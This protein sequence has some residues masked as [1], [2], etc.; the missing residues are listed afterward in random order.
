MNDLIIRSAK[1]LL[2]FSLLF[3]L[4]SVRTNEASEVFEARLDEIAKVFETYFPVVE[5]AVVSVSGSDIRINLGKKNGLMPGMVVAISREG[6]ELYHPVTKEALGKYEEEIGRLELKEAGDDYATGLLVGEKKGEIKTGDKARVTG[7]KIKVAL[8]PAN[9]ETNVF[10]IDQFADILEETGRFTVISGGEI[11]K[12][13]KEHPDD[14]AAKIAKRAGDAFKLTNLF[15]IN[16]TASKDK[17][18]FSAELI[19][20]PN[21]TQVAG[22]TAILRLPP[23][24]PMAI[25]DDPQLKA[26]TMKK[27]EFWRKEEMPFGIRWLS[28]G[29]VDGDGKNEIIASNGNKIR[30]YRYTDGKFDLIWEEKDAKSAYNQLYMDVADINGN[31]RAEIFVTNLIKDRLYSYV[32]EWKDG[33]FRKIQKDMPFF[34]RAITMPDGENILL[35]QRIGRTRPFED[36]VKKLK[37]NGE[38]YVEGDV[39]ALPKNVNIYGFTIADLDGNG[40]DEIIAIDDADY[41]RMYS[42]D[43]KQIWRSPDRYGGYDTSFDF[44][45]VDGM[46]GAREKRVKIKG[47][48]FVKDI[49]GDGRRELIVSRNVPSAYF[50]EVFRGYLYGEMYV[51]HWNGIALSELWKINRVAGFIEDFTI[52]DF[53]NE[54]FDRLILVTT[55]ILTSSKIEELFKSKSDIIIYNLP[56][57]G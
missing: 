20:L 50:F 34:L 48:L 54:G 56:E 5:G 42:M 29:D 8:I 33:E 36:A 25:E 55:P 35:S 23:K 47:R 6:K 1:Y 19:S 51:F 57:R 53:T 37:W 3:I 32:I 4:T 11:D 18:L 46:S 43:G 26:F 40:D 17:T 41:I 28:V 52:A 15:I 27:K 7:G 16:T 39:F 10:I 2:L 44:D 31:G 38:G 49:D 14:N 22:I 24:G 12:I 13:K 9:A 21:N 45:Y 30:I